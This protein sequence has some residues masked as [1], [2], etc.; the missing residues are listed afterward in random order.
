[1]FINNRNINRTILLIYVCNVSLL[2]V[3]NDIKLQAFSGLSTKDDD[4]DR[5]PT[6]HETLRTP[7]VRQREKSGRLVTDESKFT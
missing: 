7:F 3:I 6:D 4:N 2:H 1:M 5:I